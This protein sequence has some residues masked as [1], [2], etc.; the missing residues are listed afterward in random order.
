LTIQQF[1]QLIDQLR[2]SVSILFGRDPLAQH[3][4]ALSFLWSHQKAP[5]HRKEFVGFK[6]PKSGA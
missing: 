2:E 5:H 3:R 6:N 4:H 1:A